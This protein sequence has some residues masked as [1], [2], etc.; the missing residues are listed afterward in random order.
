ML[1]EGIMSMTIEISGDLEPILKAEAVKTGVDPIA[2]TNQL[3]RRLLVAG[4]SSPPA[5]SSEE[6]R[7]LNE[8]NQG[9]P[10]EEMDYYQTLIRKRQDE[11]ISDEEFQA[12]DRI[13]RRL[14]ALQLGRVQSLVK[15]AE[16]WNL[17]L[18]A[19]MTQLEIQPPDVF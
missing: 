6:A 16:L 3:L 11:T 5:L 19:V 17:P 8:I 14:E 13:T 7:L 18:A 4:K 1:H 9:L 12:L 10:A 15:L 2:Y